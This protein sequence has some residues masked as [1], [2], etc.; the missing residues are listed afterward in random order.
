MKKKSYEVIPNCL[1]LDQ[2]SI[3]TKRIYT[4]TDSLFIRINLKI[5]QLPCSMFNTK[6]NESFLLII[7]ILIQEITLD[8]SEY[9]I[10]QIKQGGSLRSLV[11]NAFDCYIVASEFTAILLQEWIWNLMSHEG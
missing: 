2:S 4:L 8:I 9:N 7:F 5:K 10:L 6:V 11:I 1:P 3:N